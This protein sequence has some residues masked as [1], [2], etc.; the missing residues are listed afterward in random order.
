MHRDS[1]ESDERRTWRHESLI[2]VVRKEPPPQN[3]RYP[4]KMFRIP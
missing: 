2:L 4:P 3:P 1:N